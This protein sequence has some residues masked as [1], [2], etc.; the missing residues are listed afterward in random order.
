MYWRAVKQYDSM[1][2]M[3]NL[4]FVSYHF[5]THDKNVLMKEKRIIEMKV[6][7]ISQLNRATQLE[8]ITSPSGF[9]EGGL[10]EWILIILSYF[11]VLSGLPLL[12][13]TEFSKDLEFHIG[14][15]LQY[16][17]RMSKLHH[18]VCIYTIYVYG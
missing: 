16:N 14:M 10:F 12:M 11:F 2:V 15:S 8:I 1:N 9:R 18:C 6:W 13:G 7:P 3:R 5:P 4:V 17:K